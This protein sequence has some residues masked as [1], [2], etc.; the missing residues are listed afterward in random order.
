MLE[1]RAPTMLVHRHTSL[2]A[3]AAHVTVCNCCPQHHHMLNA[4]RIAVQAFRKAEV[5]RP[6]PELNGHV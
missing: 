2:D 4:M 3:A 6:V 5:H 1:C